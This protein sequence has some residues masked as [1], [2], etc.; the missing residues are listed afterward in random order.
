MKENEVE[1][2]PIGGIWPQQEWE[3]HTEVERDTYQYLKERPTIMGDPPCPHCHS[4]RVIA[5]SHGKYYSVM[6]T[7]P[8][9]VVGINE[10]GN[11]STGICLYCI[12]QH[13]TAGAKYGLENVDY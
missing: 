3:I 4:P 11:N 6:W 8:K 1:K 5:P 10:G 9:I 13:T 12:L 7:C 2:I